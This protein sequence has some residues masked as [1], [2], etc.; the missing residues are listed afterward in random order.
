[1]IQPPI[2]LEAYSMGI[3]PM[4][5]SASGEIQWHLPQRRGIIPLDERFSVPSNLRRKYNKKPFKL[6]INVA[7]PEVI[8]HCRELR[9][10]ETWINQEIIDSYVELHRLG[11]AHSFEAWQ[12]N[13]LVG[14]LYGIAFGKV[15]FGESMFSR[16]TDASKI[17]LVYLVE[18]LRQKQFQLL[19]SQYLNPHLMQFGAYEI[20]SDEYLELLNKALEGFERPWS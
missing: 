18:Q 15:F 14:G 16:V 11:Y 8:R 7:F 9:I 12:E 2:L 20:S 19:D 13:E 3:F 10:G 5:D 4:A 1:M 6:T 17:C